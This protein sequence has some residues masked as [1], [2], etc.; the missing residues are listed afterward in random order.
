MSSWARIGHALQVHECIRAVEL[1]DD[2]P[3]PLRAALSV[4][5]A[6]RVMDPVSGDSLVLEPPIAR[7]A[8]AER[9]PH[10]ELNGEISPPPAGG[11]STTS[12]IRVR[13]GRARNL[14]SPTRRRRASMGTFAAF[15]PPRP[16]QSPETGR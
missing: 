5:R 15:A 11:I 14:P 13:R 2:P 1:R 10:L 7:A 16:A 8:A 4:C 9:Y 12:R 6:L 3:S